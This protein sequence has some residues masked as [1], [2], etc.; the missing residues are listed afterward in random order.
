MR[1]PDG[2][3]LTLDAFTAGANTS[4][5]WSIVSSQELSKTLRID[6]EYYQPR[7]LD[8]IRFLQHEGSHEVVSL[9]SQLISI[10]GGA[11][12][13]GA[14][15]SRD[16]IPFLRV[17]NIM[18]GYLNLEDVTYIQPEVHFNLLKR[19]R[20]NP[21]DVLLTIT[22]MSYGKASYVP[23]DLG[24]ANIN[25]HSVRMKFNADFLPEYVA[26]FLN[27][28][29]G[30]LQ[31]DMKVTGVT[32]P[33]LDYG[34]IRTVL[35]PKIQ[36]TIQENIKELLERSQTQRV[37]AQSLFVEASNL[38][39]SELGL[40]ISSV[41][42]QL[43]YISQFSSSAPLERLDAE[44]F[45]PRYS[46]LYN[47]ISNTGRGA[48]LRD[49]LAAPVR[50]GVQPEYSD[51]GEVLVINSQHV[52]KSHIELA[53]N[54]RAS[55]EFLSRGNNRRAT[56]QPYD[57]LLNSTG[58]I[59][60]GRC[61]VMLD[62][63]LAMVDGHVSIIRPTHDLDPVYLSVFLNST[64]GQLQTERGWTGSSGQI[65]LRPDTIERFMIWVPPRQ[66]Q[67][68]VRDLVERSNSARLDAEKLLDDAKRRVE[69]VI[70]S[71]E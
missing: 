20:L 11:T 34:E 21:G 27:S 23:T 26:T 3:K 45:Q 36:M 46:Q 8:N 7:Y 16:G 12:P 61:Q 68:E 44:Y 50:R 43:T 53:E 38:V 4:A 19:S 35:I 24:E 33:A 60:I 15:Y 39:S 28:R 17:Q 67:D 32:R 64:P 10:S 30:K 13:L 66:L 69:Q 31:S 37:L 9:G 57:V 56:V 29:F 22:G 52:G 71:G 41:D 1:R 5:V 2:E 51:E 47:H 18:P 65:E 55:Y 42:H 49:Y 48:F 54:R 63:V 14:S 59:T 62:D 6:A 25:Q 58:Y 70:T 40:E